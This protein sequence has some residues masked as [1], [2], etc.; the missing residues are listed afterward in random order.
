[1]AATGCEAGGGVV[2]HGGGDAVD[3]DVSLASGLQAFPVIGRL[4][5]ERSS[6]ALAAVTTTIPA[7]RSRP[8]A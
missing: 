8:V 4:R 1:M 7:A 2:G 6:L 3:E 5:W